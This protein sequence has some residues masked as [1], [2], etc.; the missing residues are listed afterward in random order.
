[1]YASAHCLS[2]DD[3]ERNSFAFQ[4][5]LYRAARLSL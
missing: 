1:M 3:N 4:Q 2:G 5:M